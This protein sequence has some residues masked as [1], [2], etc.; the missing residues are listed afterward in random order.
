[1]R[2][3]TNV[4]TDRA[5]PFC[6]DRS[7][8]EVMRKMKQKRGIHGTNAGGVKIL[9]QGFKIP[10]LPANSGGNLRPCFPAFAPQPKRVLKCRLF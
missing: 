4:Q 6:N 2:Y 5:G 3:K 8:Y 10:V 7:P 1:M 9:R